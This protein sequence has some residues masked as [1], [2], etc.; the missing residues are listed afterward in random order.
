[1]GRAHAVTTNA[2]GEKRDLP[3]APLVRAI[4]FAVASVVLALALPLMAVLCLAV[5]RSSHGPILHREAGVD[6]KGRPV[7]LLS[8]R[9]AVDGAG[10]PHHGRVRAVIGA[11]DREALTAVG[12]IMRATRTDRLPR[13]FNVL[14]GQAGLFGR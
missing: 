3:V 13:L 5:R 7:E 12:R 1:M 6:R 11:S 10:T 9:T 14:A 4:E 8:F 2:R